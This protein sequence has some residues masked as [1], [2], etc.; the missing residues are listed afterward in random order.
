MIAYLR[1]KVLTTTAETA[2]IDI[3]GVG[4]EV[5]CSAVHFARSQSGNM[6]NFTPICR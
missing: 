1:G 3:G 5:Y 2:I 6:S 4:Y